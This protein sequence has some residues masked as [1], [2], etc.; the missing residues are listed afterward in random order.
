MAKRVVI[1]DDDDDMLELLRMVLLSASFEIAG[2][3]ID[4]DEALAMWRTERD[5]GVC[6]VILDQRM[7]GLYGIEVAAAIRAQDPNQT[8]LLLSAYIDE[9]TEE[10][11]RK[12]GI[13]ACVPKQD[14]LLI[15]GHPVL[16]RACLEPA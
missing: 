7:P 15:P 1:A 4:G 14:V 8:I 5:E 13:E 10:R 16:M 11:A 9:A 2:A 3:A 6:A 12:V